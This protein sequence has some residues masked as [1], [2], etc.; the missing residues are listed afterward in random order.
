MTNNSALALPLCP[1][2][3][4]QNCLFS[5]SHSLSKTGCS[6]PRGRTAQGVWD[7]Q[8][9]G[10][11][12]HTKVCNAHFGWLIIWYAIHAWW[13]QERKLV[14]SASTAHPVR[15]SREDLWS[16]LYIRMINKKEKKL[17]KN[18]FTEGVL[19][20]W[21]LLAIMV[22]VCCQLC[23]GNLTSSTVFIVKSILASGHSIY[24]SIF[25]HNLRKL[26]LLLAQYLKQHV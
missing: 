12:M 24:K 23:K 19:L 13:L 20:L 5:R 18:T 8:G 4:L 21:H 14:M 10:G 3:T 9:D 16:F 7:R 26:T 2:Q 22:I 25:K 6:G 17:R 1:S 11:P 15:L